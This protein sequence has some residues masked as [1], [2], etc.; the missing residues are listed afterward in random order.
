[1]WFFFFFFPSWS[2]SIHSNDDINRKS[3]SETKASPQKIKKQKKNKG[4]SPPLLPAPTAKWKQHCRN[5]SLQEFLVSR[6]LCY[7]SSGALAM[8]QRVTYSFFT[9]TGEQLHIVP[10]CWRTLFT[11]PPQHNG[12][13]QRDALEHI[14]GCVCYSHRTGGWHHLFSFAGG[15]STPFCWVPCSSNS[16]SQSNNWICVIT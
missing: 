1:M 10:P 7:M 12:P 14:E 2:L 4:V 13:S 16:K 9:P 3:S 11:V 15:T 6:I 8:V 5:V